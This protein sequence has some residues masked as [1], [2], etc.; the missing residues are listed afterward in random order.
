[1]DDN[2]FAKLEAEMRR[3]ERKARPMR[4]KVDEV[5]GWLGAAFIAFVTFCFIFGPLVGPRAP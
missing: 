4:E 5:R 1:V 3:T 2:R